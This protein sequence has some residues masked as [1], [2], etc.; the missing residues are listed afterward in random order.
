VDSIIAFVFHFSSL[1]GSKQCV[2]TDIT[3]NQL[4]RISP[5]GH[6]MRRDEG[7]KE[8]FV[9]DDDDENEDGESPGGSSWPQTFLMAD[10]AVRKLYRRHAGVKGALGDGV[11]KQPITPTFNSD[12]R[13]L[14]TAKGGHRMHGG[15][16]V[17]PNATCIQATG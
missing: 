17:D 3:C 11:G 5:R 10:C 2:G 8:G 6:A 4:G 12:A 16:A 13:L 9:D 7:N 15:T 14:M 1:A